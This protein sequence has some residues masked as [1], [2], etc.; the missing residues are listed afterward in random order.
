[1]RG[2]GG[3]YQTELVPHRMRSSPTARRRDGEYLIDDTFGTVI[4]QGESLERTTLLDAMVANT[5]N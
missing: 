1:M 2:W 5:I 4:Y 3:P